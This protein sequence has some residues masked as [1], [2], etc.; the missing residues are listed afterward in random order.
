MRRASITLF[1]C[2]LLQR[3]TL[4]AEQVVLHRENFDGYLENSESVLVHFTAP[5]CERCK[6][7]EHVR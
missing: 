1:A 5:W 6:V 2:A 7:R 3:G 4:G